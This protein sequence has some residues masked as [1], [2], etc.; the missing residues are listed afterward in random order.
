MSY[1][2][3]RQV[4]AREFPPRGGWKYRQPETGWEAPEPKIDD[5]TATANKIL[6]H[7]LANPGYKM[8]ATIEA[9]AEDLA[10]YTAQRIQDETP[11]HINH[12]LIQT[13][14]AQKK[15]PEL[16]ANRSGVLQVGAAVVQA[17]KRI[18][19]NA[20]GARILA[21]WIGSGAIPESTETATQRA[22]VCA[23]CPNNITG[24]KFEAT[25]AETIRRH[26]SARHDLKLS[27]PVDD[28]IDTCSVCG[29]YLKLKVWLPI[30]RIPKTEGLPD[31]CW[32]MKE[33][34][35]RQ[36]LRIGYHGYVGDAS[37]F[38]SAARSYLQAFTDG[39]ASVSVAITR[40]HSQPAAGYA[41]LDW[42][43]D[44]HI[45]HGIPTEF[46]SLTRQNLTLVFMTAWE[47]DRLHP[48]WAPVLNRAQEVWVPS[49]FNQQIFSR[50]I[51]AP[52]IT[53]PHPYTGPE[54]PEITNHDVLRRTGIN[55]DDYVFYSIM[56]W[57]ERKG[58]ADTIEAYLRAFPEDGEHILVIKANPG[59][60]DPGSATL[61]RLR[62]A[63]K[64]KARV[65]IVCETWPDNLI[66]NLHA[67]GDCYVSLH[68][69]EGFGLPAFDAA[70][71]GKQVIATNWSGTEDFLNHRSHLLVPFSMG[72][73][74]QQYKYYTKDMLWAKPDVA[75]ASDYMAHLGVGT[76][77][78]DTDSTAEYL[79]QKFSMKEIS[80]L[81]LARLRNL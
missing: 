68:R 35:E 63:T 12:W 81:T 53:V 48:A 69:G 6:Q 45:A 1:I 11:E 29:C 27:T 73:V 26:E 46:E 30:E 9:A 17:V 23:G 5:F 32:I 10:A 50:S 65:S 7:R 78:L 34:A 19:R 44:V 64:S 52:V 43:S 71:M 13:D 28:K 16:S 49:T 40:G 42:K 36:K 59:A 75:T 41:P 66:L 14:P 58:P 2:L 39:G 24:H 57:Q 72:R 51:R 79:R 70:C 38:G 77:N 20:A 56:V 33:K 25:I 22:Q 4:A 8:A 3:N 74:D 15:T 67:R 21:E 47:T 54:L 62:E 18:R 80:K 61:A 60:K 76:N 31:F 37:G 55:R